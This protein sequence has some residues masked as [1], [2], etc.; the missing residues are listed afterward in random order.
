MN[1]TLKRTLSINLASVV[2]LSIISANSDGAQVQLNIQPGVQLS[3]PTPNTTNTYHLQWSPGSGGTWNDLVA[4]V[5][6][7]GT[8]NTVFDPIPSGAR[9][10]Q[11]MEI[12]PGTPP[13]TASPANGG[14]ETGNGS[15]A[16]NWTVDTAAGG[17]VYGVRTND[18]PNSGSFNF[19]VHLAST[20]AGPV[21]QFNQSAIPVT[22]GTIYPFTFYAKALAGSQ[23]QSCTVANS[24]ER[25]RG[26]GLSN[27]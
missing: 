9:H 16:N 6:G 5:T 26:H 13:S 7:N 22:G 3:W 14:F 1:T 18:S 23:G 24:M 17:P 27:I 4:A 8:T 10:Y 19:Q 20:G 2:F 25:R 15:S 11:D 21:V 12:I